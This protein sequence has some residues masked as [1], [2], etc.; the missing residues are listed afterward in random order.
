MLGIN[1]SSSLFMFNPEPGVVGTIGVH[2]EFPATVTAA[3]AGLRT[4]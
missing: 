3:G 4:T 2:T 1:L